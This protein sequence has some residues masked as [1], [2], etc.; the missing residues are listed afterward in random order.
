MD[1]AELNRV[2]F[3]DD[4]QIAAARMSNHQLASFLALKLEIQRIELIDEFQRREVVEIPLLALRLLSEVLSE[5][6]MGNAVKVVPRSCRADYPG[7]CGHI[8]RFPP[9]LSKTAR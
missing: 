2:V 5:I 3:A 8:E 4:K 1:V 7:G 9:S 6:A